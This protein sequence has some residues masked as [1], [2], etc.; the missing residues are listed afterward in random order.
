MKELS[1]SLRWGRLVHTRKHRAQ[2]LDFIVGAASEVFFLHCIW[3]DAQAGLAFAAEKGILGLAELKQFARTV[4][5]QLLH[6]FTQLF[7]A[8][9]RPTRPHPAKLVCPRC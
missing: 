3:L 6:L 4:A 8:E 9:G 1:D 2:S 5:T 7:Q